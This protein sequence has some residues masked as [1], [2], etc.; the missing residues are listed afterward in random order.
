MPPGP[1]RRLPADTA[2]AVRAHARLASIERIALELADH[3]LA[4]GATRLEIQ[5]DVTRWHLACL[6]NGQD[7][8]LR[9]HGYFLDWQRCSFD[10]APIMAC[11]P[12]LGLL[13]V[14]TGAER[15]WTVIQRVR[16]KR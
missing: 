6:Y 5:M 9:T 12:W 1:V 8:S 10:Q 7:E 3:A 13:E 2:S 14:H 16:T 4:C 11:L 15:P